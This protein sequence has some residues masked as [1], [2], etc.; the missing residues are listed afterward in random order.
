LVKEQLSRASEAVADLREKSGVADNQQEIV[1]EEILS[2]IQNRFQQ[3]FNRT[4]GVSTVLEGVS[5]YFGHGGPSTV[6]R[7]EWARAALVKIYNR[8]ALPMPTSR[9]ALV[10]DIVKHLSNVSWHATGAHRFMPMLLAVTNN[11]RGQDLFSPEPISELRQVDP[12]DYLGINFHLYANPQGVESDWI[13][14]RRP[15]LHVPAPAGSRPLRWLDIGSS[16]DAD[17]AQTLNRVKDVF[18]NVIGRDIEIVGTDMSFPQATFENDAV[19]PSPFSS[20]EFKR[21]AKIIVNGVEYRNAA[22]PQNDFARPEFDMGRFDYISLCM[23]LHHLSPP[24]AS[25]E[26]RPLDTTAEWFD[27]AGQKQNPA[28]RLSDNQR[29][30]V[31]RLLRSLNVGGLCFLNITEGGREQPPNS[32]LF[33]IFRRD[34]ENRFQIYSQAIPFRPSGE[35]FRSAAF[36][37]NPRSGFAKKGVR[38]S[39]PGKS[40]AV[41]EDVSRWLDRADMLTFR[42]QYREHSAWP[43]VYEAAQ[44][45]DE[46]KSLLDVFSAYLA[47]VPESEPLKQ[48]LLDRMAQMDGEFTT[49]TKPPKNWLVLAFGSLVLAMRATMAFVAEKYTQLKTRNRNK[50]WDELD[51]GDVLKRLPESD[52]DPR[53]SGRIVPGAVYYKVDYLADEMLIPGSEIP[54]FFDPE[55]DVTLW[56]PEDSIV[57]TSSRHAVGSRDHVFCSGVEIYGE[58]VDRETGAR[59]PVTGHAHFVPNR[60]V[61]WQILAK[62]FSNASQFHNVVLVIN[63]PLPLTAEERAIL[64]REGIGVIENIRDEYASHSL[65]TRRRSLVWFVPTERAPWRFLEPKHVLTTFW[66]KGP[67]ETNRWKNKIEAEPVAEVLSFVSRGEIPPV[68]LNVP[69]PVVHVDDI[70]GASI[71][72]I[73]TVVD[74]LDDRSQDQVFVGR[75]KASLPRG[76]MKDAAHRDFITASYAV[77]CLL[78]WRGAFVPVAAMTKPRVYVMRDRVEPEAFLTALLQTNP[79]EKT[80]IFTPE[81]N[82]D[83]YKDILVAAFPSN[84]FPLEVIAATVPEEELAR[85]DLEEMIGVDPIDVVLVLQGIQLGDQDD[86]DFDLTPILFEVLV[87]LDRR[88]LGQIGVIAR[89]FLEAA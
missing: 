41:Y 24:D 53:I 76:L 11:V 67:S 84:K 54:S 22:L 37:M 50:D 30:A 38:L 8:P 2:E 31:M 40:E 86:F 65:V 79:T 6:E 44:V 20:P 17:G 68:L 85:E 23:M 61:H 15:S 4:I 35:T 42:Y 62:L 56:V 25:A 46:G 39:W 21:D 47:D 26:L 81:K 78:A 71:R 88:Q 5:K 63:K 87:P 83:Y 9:E 70:L 32:D 77:L 13:P 48:K 89:R 58:K 59:V 7:H 75:M 66:R 60:D 28:Y 49:N 73:G 10:D 82:V 16:P 64:E 29:L 45:V 74:E 80:Q 72:K 69:D 33:L 27:E 12:S 51:P 34:A 19:T 57:L 1:P 14:K 3:Q 43:R 36:L 18:R 55:M 52:K